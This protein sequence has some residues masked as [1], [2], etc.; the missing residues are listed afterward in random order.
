MSLNVADLVKGRRNFLMDLKFL[1]SVVDREQEQVERAIKT[2]LANPK[3]VP[4]PKDYERIAEQYVQIIEALDLFAKLLKSGLPEGGYLRQ[5]GRR[6]TRRKS[7]S[8]LS[9]VSGAAIKIG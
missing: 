3:R 9:T 7:R 4:E 6:R 5:Y 1:M 2:M 8:N